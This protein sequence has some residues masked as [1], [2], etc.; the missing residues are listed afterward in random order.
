MEGGMGVSSHTLNRYSNAPPSK[1][2]KTSAWKEAYVLVYMQNRYSNALSLKTLKP[3]WNVSI[4]KQA[5][6]K[7][8]CLQKH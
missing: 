2:L 5:F 7:K 1:T 4:Y 6:L 3:P 8:Y